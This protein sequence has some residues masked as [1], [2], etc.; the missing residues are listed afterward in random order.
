MIRPVLFRL[1]CLIVLLAGPVAAQETRIAAVVNDE[2]I[3]LADLD[4]R[5]RLALV[6]S[7]IT[8]TPENRRRIASQVLRGLIDEKLQQQEAKRLNV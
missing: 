6:S 3:S 1:F 2:I 5:L 4:E 7:S 8:D